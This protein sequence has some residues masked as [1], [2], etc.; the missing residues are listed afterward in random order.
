MT[1]RVTVGIPTWN[2]AESLAVAMRSAL[3]QDADVIVRVS[4]ND[5]SD[6]TRAVVAAIR[7]D[8]V[9]YRR[10]PEQVSPTENFN[11]LFRDVVTPYAMVLCDDDVLEPGFLRR[12]VAVL[13]ESPSVGLTFGPWWTALP[14]GERVLSSPTGWTTARYLS[15]REFVSLSMQ[16]MLGHISGSLLRTAVL[17]DQ[18]F[19]PRDGWADDEGLWLKVGLVADVVYTAEPTTTVARSEDSISATISS[20]LDADIL[21][22]EVKLRVLDGPAA[23]HPDAAAWRATVEAWYRRRVMWNAGAALRTTRSVGAVR[24]VLSRGQSVGVRVAADPKAWKAGVAGAGGP[25]LAQAV[26][27]TKQRLGLRR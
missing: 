24:S 10:Q 3:E 17:P 1:P 20:T 11:S 19:D 15:G 6:N 13:D 23:T 22:R 4:D 9:E 25:R 12:S 27:S 16:G 7:D 14:S 2:R 5:S 18:P 8:R 26:S 21:R